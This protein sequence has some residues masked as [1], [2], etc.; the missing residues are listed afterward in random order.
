MFG[1][2][3]TG[4]HIVQPKDGKQLDLFEDYVPPI[5]RLDLETRFRDYAMFDMDQIQFLAYAYGAEQ[6]RVCKMYNNS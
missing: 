2:R 6:V 3:T 4:L 5:L 1:Y